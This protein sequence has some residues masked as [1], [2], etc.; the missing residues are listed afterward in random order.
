MEI[1]NIATSALQSAGQAARIHA[2]NIVNANSVSTNNA[3]GSVTPFRPQAP[4]FSPRVNGGGVALLTQEV[5][6]PINLI[7]ET[8]G[9]ITASHQYKAAANLVRSAD[10]MHATLLRTFA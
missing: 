7:T 2:H 6:Q 8:L 3:A 4:I 10:E 1:L 5:G 9:L